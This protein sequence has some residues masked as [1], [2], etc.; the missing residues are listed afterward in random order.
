MCTKSKPID[1][2]TAAN[3][4]RKRESS[5]SDLE[6]LDG[7]SDAV[8]RLLAKHPNASPALLERISH[9]SDK[10]VRQS[11]TLNASAAK[12]TLIRLAPQFPAEFFR[13]PAV[14]WLLLEDPSLPFRLGPGVLKNALKQPD[15]PQALMTWAAAKGSEQEKLALAMNASAPADIV[16]QLSLMPDPVGQAA[17]SHAKGPLP[18]ADEVEDGPSVVQAEVRAALSELTPDEA[19]SYWNRGI[20]GPT[21]WAALNLRARLEVLGLGDWEYR[22]DWLTRHPDELPAMAD[23]ELSTWLKAKRKAASPEFAMA[24][25]IL[26]GPADLEKLT[27]TKDVELLTLVA[28]HPTLPP[29]IL[30]IFAADKRTAMREAVAANPSTPAAALQQLAADKQASV[31]AEVAGNPAAAPALVAS[32]ERDKAPEVRRAMKIASMPDVRAARSVLTSAEQLLQLAGAKKAEVRLSVARNPATPEAARS[33]AYESLID[34]AGPNKLLELADEPGCPVALRNR[35]RARRWWRELGLTAERQALPA[36][37]QPLPPE[38]DVETLL[39]MLRDESDAMLLDPGRTLLARVLG[40]REGD[41]LALPNDEADA[42]CNARARAVRLMG[43]MHPQAGPEAMAKRC[44]STDWVERLAIACNPACAPSILSSLENDANQTVARQ[45][46]STRQAKAAQ[47]DKK[48]AIVESEPATEVPMDRAVDEILVRLKECRTW[49]LQGSV[50]WHALAFGQRLGV[51][52]WPHDLSTVS[53]QDL[54]TVLETLCALPIGADAPTTSL[55]QIW[56]V[57]QHREL[58]KP[59]AGCRF[60]SKEHGRALVASA[61]ADVRALVAMNPHLEVAEASR[62]AADPEA[63]VRRCAVLGGRVPESVIDQLLEDADLY[64]RATAAQVVLLTESR[65]QLLLKER[66]ESVRAGLA[67]NPGLSHPLQLEILADKRPAVRAAQASNPS[68][69]PAVLSELASDSV[70]AVRVAAARN[71][72]VSE[73]ALEQLVA[74]KHRDVREAVAG[75]QRTSM[76]L[77]LRLACDKDDWVR[78]AA[79]DRLMRAM[80]IGERELDQVRGTQNPDLLR[81]VAASPRLDPGLMAALL[82]ASSV[83][84]R[85]ELAA[86]ANAPAEVIAKLASDPDANVQRAVLSHRHAPVDLLEQALANGDVELRASV[87]RNPNL[88]ARLLDRL[89]EDAA[90]QV[91]KQVLNRRDISLGLLRRMAPDIADMGIYFPALIS[92]VASEAAAAEDLRWAVRESFYI[93]RFFALANPSYPSQHKETDTADLQELILCGRPAVR[94]PPEAAS[95]ENLR[96]ALQ[97]LSLLPAKPDSKWATKAAKSKDWLERLAAVLSG[98]APPSLLQLLVDDP[99]QTVRQLAIRCLRVSA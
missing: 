32:L 57:R 33:A 2:R 4:A 89:A 84:L 91:R 29:S 22:D 27:A 35:A 56:D 45:V 34:E 72:N 48:K 66:N 53:G 25:N 14:D 58:L 43:L 85:R 99:E 12:E 41:L 49:L 38:P 55:S 9:S 10:V 83:S 6:H 23:E 80:H 24:R 54:T 62:L 30:M 18:K 20:V 92:A 39:R 81:L 87:A 71:A 36:S 16:A 98:L 31:R 67:K 7:L 3:L 52:T 64:V 1:T 59:I 69:E 46:A 65:L 94:P 15:C 93:A 47:Q 42:A 28:R 79:E 96:A 90:P 11:V 44:K 61:S 13:N 95:E 77:T 75:N 26:A 40:Y 63:R 5:A 97:A 60:L 78:R 37:S 76:A 21:K 73:A 50:W 70:I 8:D 19:K 17:R 68:I 82:D 86:N 88:P 74:D 51:P